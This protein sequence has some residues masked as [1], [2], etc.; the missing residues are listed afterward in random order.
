MTEHIDDEKLKFDIR[1]RFDFISKFLN[2]TSEDI[3]VLNNFSTII[4]PIIPVIVDSVYRRLF[5]YDITK[6]YF[7]INNE[8]FDES[9][10]KN[11]NLSLD[12]PQMIYRKDILSGYLKRLFLQHEWTNE[13]LN[14]L[15]RFGQIQTNKIGSTSINIDY[16]HI[17]TTLTYI[18]NLLIE[19][20]WSNEHLDDLTKKRILLALNKVF[21]I[22]TDLF[23]MHYL[24]P[25]I[26]QKKEKCTCS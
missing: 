21:R 2:F 23:L 16:I 1:Y 19:I 22:Q 7:I 6:N 12:S 20:I 15:S 9:I 3:K 13:F 17:N 10:R 18:E 24:Q 11:E 8:N 14:Y 4:L 26:N 25:T 5:Q